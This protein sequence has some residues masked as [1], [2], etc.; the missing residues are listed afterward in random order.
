MMSR[1]LRRASGIF[2]LGDHL[3]LAVAFLD[4]LFQVDD[5]FRTRTRTGLPNRGCFR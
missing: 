3:D 5:V 2:D 1:I 4:D